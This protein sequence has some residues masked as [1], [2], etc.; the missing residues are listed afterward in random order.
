[1]LGADSTSHVS[2]S[3]ERAA[4]YSHR[5]LV[6]TGTSAF[7]SAFE[8]RTF[9]GNPLDW[10]PLSDDTVRHHLVKRRRKSHREETER[11][12]GPPK[13]RHGRCRDS[14]RHRT[15]CFGTPRTL[16]EKGKRPARN[17]GSCQGVL[18][19][20]NPLVQL[21]PSICCV[22]RVLPVNVEEQVRKTKL[23]RFLQILQFCWVEATAI[24]LLQFL[25]KLLNRVTDHLSE[26]TCLLVVQAALYRSPVPDGWL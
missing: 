15:C 4:F 7:R 1:M 20:P 19:G 11:L 9:V 10:Q 25:F 6:I 16:M 8:R 5:S 12:E 26:D 17:P 22:R 14:R 23:A 13:G 21:D 18:Y 3:M 2:S 24:C